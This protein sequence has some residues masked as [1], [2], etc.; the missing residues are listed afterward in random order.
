MPHPRARLWLAAPLTALAL[1]A[2]ACTTNGG[3]ASDEDTDGDAGTPQAIVSMSPTTTEMLYAVGAGD[4]VVAVDDQS[5]YPDGVPVTEL[6]GYTPNLEA[7]LSYDP[8]LVVLT[9]DNGDVVAGLE[10]AGVDVLQLPAGDTVEDT[11]TQIEQVGAA[12]GNVGEAA[13]VVSQMQTDIAEIVATVPERETPLTYFHELD[14]TFYTVTDDTYVGEVYSMLGLTSIATGDTPYPQLSEEII[15]EADPDFIFL[16]DG[17]CCGVTPEVVAQRP[18]WDGL[19]A[20]REGRVHIVDEDTASR[21]SP[22]IVDFLR[23][24]A[25]V[26]A[27]APAAQPTP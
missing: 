11:Y 19:T 1:A 15:L 18:G 4:R 6:S 9:D 10:R 24:V 8:D 22:R 20:V 2:G 14:E 17:Q 13:E 3:G 26:V 21:W 5:D 16:A 27:G 7:I 12:T 23:E 25:G